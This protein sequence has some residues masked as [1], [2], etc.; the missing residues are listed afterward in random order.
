[1]HELDRVDV[2]V[3]YLL[4]FIS[5]GRLSCLETFCCHLSTLFVQICG[6]RYS[7]CQLPPSHR[8]LLVQKFVLL[9]SND[10]DGYMSREY[11]EDGKDLNFGRLNDS[12]RVCLDANPDEISRFL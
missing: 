4:E 1:M 11:R 5:E 2:E 7:W 6:I 10:D 9:G 3:R 12:V 8:L